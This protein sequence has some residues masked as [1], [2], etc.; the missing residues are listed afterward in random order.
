MAAVLFLEMLVSRSDAWS[1][2]QSAQ[3]GRLSRQRDLGGSHP[4]YAGLVSILAEAFQ[5]KHNFG[6]LHMLP[7]DR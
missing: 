3:G 2:S 1:K 7:L 4:I 6:E 5:P